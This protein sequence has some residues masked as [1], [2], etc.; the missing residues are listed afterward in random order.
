MLV[1]FYLMAKSAFY[2]EHASHFFVREE[3][4]I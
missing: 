2:T 4:Q 3:A 1:R